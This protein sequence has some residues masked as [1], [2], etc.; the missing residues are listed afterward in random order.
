MKKILLYLLTFML[1]G[2]AGCVNPQKK[3]AKPHN[4]IIAIEKVKD[5]L[6]DISEPDTTEI[7]GLMEFYLTLDTI[8]AN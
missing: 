4:W 5:E 3:Q 6:I 2:V 8:K 7:I 1:L